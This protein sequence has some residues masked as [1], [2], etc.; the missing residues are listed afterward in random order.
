[1]QI[2]LKRFKKNFQKKLFR[3]IFSLGDVQRS[4]SGENNQK[5]ND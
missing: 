5:E 1:M 4:K 3:K 2:L